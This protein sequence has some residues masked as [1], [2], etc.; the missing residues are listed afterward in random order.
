MQNDSFQKLL[1]KF[2]D[3]FFLKGILTFFLYI[4]SHIQNMTK[5]FKKSAV[6]IKKKKNYRNS[7]V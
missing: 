2:Y 4:D 5:I 6:V 7:V 3:G 1:Q